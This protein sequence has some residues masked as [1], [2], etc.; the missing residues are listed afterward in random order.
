M[1]AD[2]PILRRAA[3]VHRR[4]AGRGVRLARQ[5]PKVLTPRWGVGGAAAVFFDRGLKCPLGLAALRL[6]DALT[7]HAPEL[8]DRLFTPAGALPRNADRLAGHNHVH[9]VG[10]QLWK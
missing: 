10:V 3:P 8:V 4:H 7:P 6:G 9:R 2:S 1:P 5:T